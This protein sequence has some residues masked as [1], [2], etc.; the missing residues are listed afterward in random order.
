MA[1]PTG[2]VVVVDG[3]NANEVATFLTENKHKFEICK[4]AAGKDGDDS[5]VLYVKVRGNANGPSEL[6]FD[7][8][9]GVGAEVG[10]LD[11][12]TEEQGWKTTSLS[13]LQAKVGAWAGT[14]VGLCATANLVDLKASIFDLNLGI[15]ANCQ[16]GWSDDDKAVKVEVL[17]CGITIGRKVAIS[18]FGSSFGVDF[19]RLFK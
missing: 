17:G 4:S 12:A 14:G 6:I 9:V 1:K 16:V 5:R 10:L 8:G 19:V 13:V 11:L 7:I 2:A 15:G 3:S 18:V